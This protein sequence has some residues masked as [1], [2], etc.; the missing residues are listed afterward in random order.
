VQHAQGARLS[1]FFNSAPDFFGLDDGGG[2]IYVNKRH[3]VAI[4][5]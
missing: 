3:V 2:S 5:I 4:N 1:D